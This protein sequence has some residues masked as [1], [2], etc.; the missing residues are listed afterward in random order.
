MARQAR[1]RR[2]ARP[3]T[4][5]N[6]GP[7]PTWDERTLLERVAQRLHDDLSCT[8]VGPCTGPSEASFE[9]A[10]AVLALTGP[11]LAAAELRAYAD[12]LEE[13]LVCCDAYTG[14]GNRAGH[15]HCICYWGG[16]AAAG[17]RDRAA[18]LDAKVAPGQLRAGADPAP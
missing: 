15:G 1:I 7:R 5:T 14:R 8:C 17:A 4:G 12:V 18:E 6:A 11:I 9:T 10:R 3:G 13:E 2:K 16:A